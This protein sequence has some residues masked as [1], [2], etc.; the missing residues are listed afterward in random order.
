MCDAHAV[1]LVSQEGDRFEVSLEVANMSEFLKTIC[2][3]K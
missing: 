1:H 2:D 3:G